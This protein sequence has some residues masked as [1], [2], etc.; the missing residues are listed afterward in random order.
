MPTL[1]TFPPLPS[2]EIPNTDFSF[3]QV[4]SV[5]LMESGKEY[6]STFYIACDENGVTDQCVMELLVD[7]YNIDEENFTATWTNI[8]TCDG[9]ILSSYITDASGLIDD[10]NPI[11]SLADPAVIEL[12]KNRTE[13]FVF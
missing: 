8:D 10:S 11:Y 12:F 6:D 4:L 3:M 1:K 5:E 2:I 13:Q 7:Y 9:G